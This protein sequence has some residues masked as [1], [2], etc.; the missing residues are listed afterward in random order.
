[1]LQ[2]IVLR[3]KEGKMTRAPS[4]DEGE[5]GEGR[6]EEKKE[7]RKTRCGNDRKMKMEMEMEVETETS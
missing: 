6:R 1:M 4:I 3:V 2:S 7:Y 5:A